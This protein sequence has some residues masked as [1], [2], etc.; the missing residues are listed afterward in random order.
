MIAVEGKKIQKMFASIAGQYDLANDV[1]S[2][3]IHR[4]WKKRLVRMLNPRPGETVLDCATGTGDLA[5]LFL[6]EEP[7]LKITGLDFCSEMLDLARNKVARNKLEAYQVKFLAGDVSE[8]PF[9][10]NS[11]DIVSI[12]FGIRNVED[13]K[14]GLTEMARVLKPG[15]RLAVLEFGKPQSKGPIQSLYQFYSKKVLPHVGGVLTRNVEA[16]SYLE[17]SSS[18]FPSGQDFVAWVHQIPS[19]TV[20]KFEPLSFG[21]AYLYLAK[22]MES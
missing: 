18:H 16:Y 12:S 22:K 1:L 7:T 20:T 13:P 19:L 4:F 11:F 17:K 15:G 14:K 8:L 9:S 2:A 3:G 10:D 6:K 21:I 5:F